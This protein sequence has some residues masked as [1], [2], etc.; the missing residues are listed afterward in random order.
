H[1][2]VAQDEKTSIVFGMPREAIEK[3][4]AVAV[5][6]LDQIAETVTEWCQSK[7]KTSKS[8]KTA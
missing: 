8:K 5:K 4:G 1:S 2:T 3:G 7:T 6:P